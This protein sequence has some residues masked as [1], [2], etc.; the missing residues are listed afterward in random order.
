MARPDMDSLLVRAGWLRALAARLVT[1]A[2]TAD[3]L[4]QTTW[5]AA[6]E[7]PPRR[8]GPLEP[9]LARVVRNFARRRRRSDE[10]R[11]EH[12]CAAA[13]AEAT[14]PDRT[15]E[16]LEVQRAVVE[17]LFE[18]DE[19]FRT[20][21]V[22]RY[23]EARTSAEIARIEHVPAGT[24]RWRLKRGLDEL[25]ERLDRRFGARET[26]L[27]LL[28]PFAARHTSSAPSHDATSAAL[29]GAL[30][31]STA[32]VALTAGVVIAVA[33]LV[34][35]SRDTSAEPARE[36][37]IVADTERAPDSAFDR[38]RPSAPPL[39]V[40]AAADARESA[41]IDASAATKDVAP[42]PAAVMRTGTIDARFVDEIG[43][44]RS[45]VRFTAHDDPSWTGKPPIAVAQS[46]P[47]GRAQLEVRI[48][49]MRMKAVPGRSPELRGDWSFQ[50]TAAGADAAA[51]ERSVSVRVGET[52]HLGDVVLGVGA[53]VHGRAVDEHGIGVANATIGVADAALDEDEGWARRHGADAFHHATTTSSGTDGA[54][55]LDGVALGAHRLWAKRDDS[56]FAWSE[57][58]T[59]AGG[60]D[61]LGITLVIAPLTAADRIEG[62]VVDPLDQ[63]IAF[64]GVTFLAH[65]KRAVS[66]SAPVDANGRFSLLVGSDDSSYDFTAIDWSEHFAPASAKGVQA[67]TLDLVLRLREKEFLDVRVR[68]AHG[69]AIED[70]SFEIVSQGFGRKAVAGTE[71]AGRYRVPLPD[72]TFELEISAPGF[73]TENRERLDPHA[74]A[75]SMDVVLRRAP[76]ARGRVVADGS[77]VAGATVEAFPHWPD[78]SVTVDGFRCV[79]SSWASGKT[80]TDADGR[81]ELAC[82][83]DG[84]LWIRASSDGW[85]KG[86]LGPI[87]ALRDDD[88]YDIMLTH[89]GS[90]EGSVLLPAP[91]DAEG[92]IVAINHGDGKP[93]TV[94]AGPGGKFRFDGLVP[95]TWQVLT[96]DR[97]IDPQR[98]TH[99][100]T[101]DITPIEWSCDVVAGRTTRYDL[102][103]TRK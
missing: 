55:E 27:G 56:R 66:T 1:D 4:V 38:T 36:H 10:R 15:A 26:W 82:D 23:F 71:A 65:G 42:A 95:G 62:R 96:R 12:E 25:R 86:E 60:G 29:K 5:L 34:W 90:I 98:S 68:D 87:D 101:D 80:Q 32:K 77:P 7:H 58:F 22:L 59:V 6:L 18:I 11:S 20:A 97:E 21:I 16:K 99:S 83:L 40:V 67:G 46:G 35:W 69:G 2:A 53:R 72:D 93:R 91:Q 78:A 64:A 54:F 8:E 28:A 47:D 89:G 73:R 52:V 74:M 33:G 81:F 70:A 75:R 88:R 43:A 41:S 92:A 61:V 45:G 31:M 13:R 37:T 3:D 63:P 30:V 102:D 14:E 39:D 85:V 48:P 49:D 44:P 79:M 19:P 103:L 84:P 76:I 94:R 9:W 17:A 24:V 50:V 57:P 51:V 100:S